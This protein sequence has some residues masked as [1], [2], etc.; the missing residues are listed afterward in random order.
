MAFAGPGGGT[1]F[2][3]E[4]SSPDRWRSDL[5]FSVGEVLGFAGPG[6]GTCFPKEVSS[7]NS[8]SRKRNLRLQET[9]P[10]PGDFLWRRGLALRTR[11]LLSLPLGLSACV[12]CLSLLLGSCLRARCLL[13]ACSLRCQDSSP[14]EGVTFKPFSLPRARTPPRPAAWLKLTV[15]PRRGRGRPAPLGTDGWRAASRGPRLPYDT[16]REGELPKKGR[17]SAGYL[18]IILLYILRAPRL[19]LRA[20]RFALRAS[21]FAQVRFALRAPRCA[22]RALALPALLSA[23]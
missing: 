3:T 8:S 2:T 11:S 12:L 22:L 21:R 5:L 19:A 17:R 10:T 6:G 23:S 4:V 1:R 16:R 15:S 18:Y 14:H 20:W 9:S 13:A 7:L